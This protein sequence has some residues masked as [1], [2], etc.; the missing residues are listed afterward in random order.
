MQRLRVETKSTPKSARTGDVIESVRFIVQISTHT[1]GGLGILI[2]P[3]GGRI[4][5]LAP[6]FLVEEDEHVPRCALK[7]L[8]L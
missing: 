1:T 4:S 5:V 8:F 3:E 2:L 6:F 7:A